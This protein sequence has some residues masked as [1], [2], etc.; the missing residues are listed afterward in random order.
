MIQSG[1]A[2]LQAT[3]ALPATTTPAYRAH[4]PEPDRWRQLICLGAGGLH[5]GR[6]NPFGSVLHDA[7]GEATQRQGRHQLVAGEG[8]DGTGPLANNRTAAEAERS[9]AERGP[10]RPVAV[11]SAPLVQFLRELS[12]LIHHRFRKSAQARFHTG[13][14]ES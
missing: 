2:S 3:D 7:T 5:R 12:W 11:R 14:P 1:Q 6:Q 8:G 9:E 13:R 10:K 4:Q